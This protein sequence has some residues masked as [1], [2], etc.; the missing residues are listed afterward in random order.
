VSEDRSTPR[1]YVRRFVP[2]PV[3]KAARAARRWKARGPRLGSFAPRSALEVPSHMVRRALVPAIDVHT[4]LGRWLSDRGGW[5]QDDVHEVLDLMDSCNVAAMVN[6]DGRW[7]REL[8]ENLDRYDRAFPGRFFTFCHL[9][10]RLLEDRR[11]TG[12]LVESLKRSV[13]SGA[14]GLKVWKDLGM[15]VT[16]GGRLVL[17]DDPMLCPVWD[18][19]GE[20]QVPV[21]IHVADPV[22][23]F[24]PVDCHNERLEELL[25]HP[26]NS[27]RRGG[28]GEFDVLIDA[29]EHMVASHPRTTIIGAHVGCYPE[30]LARVSQMLDRY[31][32]FYVDTA[33]RAAE[34]GRQ[35]RRAGAMIT[36]HADRVLFGTDVF[37]L[38][39]SA[40]HRYY[41]LFETADEAFPYSD[42]AVPSQGRW[43]IY[44]LDLPAPV[45]EKMYR[46]N[47]CAVLG[48]S[49]RSARAPEGPADQGPKLPARS[50]P[51]PC[52]AA[53]DG[54]TSFHASHP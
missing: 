36:K 16:I 2:N 1:P 54:H 11:G 42:D 24:D 7:G 25:L 10:W 30:N 14:R 46:T 40:Y 43:S 47:A 44:G 51:T 5:M 38:R 31:P 19:A 26:R 32:N 49:S 53:H 6:L 35:P 21:L 12:L 18:A 13:A 48:L 22:A 23:F 33:G 41:R 28:R 34:L 3:L 4:H 8:E 9:D 17:P 15:Q 50:L 20:L 37:P 45:L 52:H 29:F 39:A 27:R